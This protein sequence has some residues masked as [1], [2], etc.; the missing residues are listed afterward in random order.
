MTDEQ[1]IQ[2]IGSEILTDGPNIPDTEIIVRGSE[3]LLASTTTLQPGDKVFIYSLN[4]GTATLKEKNI[5]FTA[6]QWIEAQGYT[7]VRLISLL[8]IEQKLS[9]LNKT[10]AKMTAVRSWID[11]ILSVYVQSPVAQS[12]WTPAPFTFEETIQDA[13]NALVS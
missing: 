6:E 1:I 4:L 11:S 10:S 3:V 12:N 9:A 5:N 13:F 8:D 2:K 7:S